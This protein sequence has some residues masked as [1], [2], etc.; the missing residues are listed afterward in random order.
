MVAI[1]RGVSAAGAGAGAGA[2][3][4]IADGADSDA[5]FFIGCRC[6]C[7]RLGGLLRFHRPMLS[8]AEGAGA[9]AGTSSGVLAPAFTLNTPVAASCNDA[10]AVSIMTLVPDPGGM[11]ERFY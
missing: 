1:S 8:G 4:G 6:S 10:A 2:A 5:S 11:P 3:A 7:R 9:G